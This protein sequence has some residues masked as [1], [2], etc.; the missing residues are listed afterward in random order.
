VV[1]RA[2]SYEDFESAFDAGD[3]HALLLELASESPDREA[4]VAELA[5]TAHVELRAWVAHMEVREDP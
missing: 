3:E 1:D 4:L 5:R 2:V